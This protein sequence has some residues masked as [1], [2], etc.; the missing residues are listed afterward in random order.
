MHTGVEIDIVISDALKAYATYQEIFATELIEKTDFPKGQNEVVF[1]IY[2]TRIHLLD[3]NP[4]AGMRAPQETVVP[5]WLNVMVPDIKETF[6]RAMDHG[7]HELMPLTDMSDFG[8]TNAV[9]ADTFGYQW[10]LHQIHKE[11]SF[12]ERKAMFEQEMDE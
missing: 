4:E 11:V 1:T 9:V 3:E 10:M 6:Q 7:W 2:G 8:V 5:I 12:E